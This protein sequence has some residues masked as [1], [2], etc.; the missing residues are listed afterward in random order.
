MLPGPNEKSVMT[1]PSELPVV[2]LAYGLLLAAQLFAAVPAGAASYA[3]D[4]AR[5]TLSATFKLSGVPAD[6]QFR[7]FSGGADFD[8][9]NPAQTRTRFDIEVA[10]FDLGDQDY[11]TELA[12]KDWFD[13]TRYP[14]ATFVSKSVKV[15][16]PGKLDVTGTM[17]IKGRAAHM[18]IPVVYRQDGQAYVFEGAAPIKR[19]A[20]TLG[21]G[22]WKDTAVLEDEVRIRFKLTLV[23][24][25]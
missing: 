11:N 15:S 6:G 23:P 12:K 2:R 20:F 1:L 10:G 14:K 22:E 19:L 16:G 7:K 17:T 13:T 8:P 21:E 9:A 18:R 25:K 4:A 5:S 3:I 24:R